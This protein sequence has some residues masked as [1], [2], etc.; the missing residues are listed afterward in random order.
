MQSKTM[1]TFHL[2]PDR[3]I[4]IRNVTLNEGKLLHPPGGNVDW[5]S[6]FGSQ[7]ACFSKKL[8]IDYCM[9]QLWH[10]WVYT[11]WTLQPTEILVHPCPLWLKSQWLAHIITK[12]FINSWMNKENV[13]CVQNRMLLS[14]ESKWNNKINML[15]I[16]GWN[17]K[18][19]ID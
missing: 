4:V 2:I 10:S 6:H 18:N 8:E 12:M 3:K 1:L 13:A 16:N 15:Y 19:Y 14:C 7:L 9:T 17:W 5:Y 11:Q